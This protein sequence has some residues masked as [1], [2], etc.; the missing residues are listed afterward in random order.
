M[1]KRGNTYTMLATV[2]GYDLTQAEWVILTVKPINRPSIEF[3]KAH[4][5]LAY[6]DGKT[7]IAYKLT[8]E[9]S[10]SMDTTQMS[11][12]VNWMLNG[13]RG[14]TRIKTIPIDRTLLARVIGGFPDMTPAPEPE[15]QADE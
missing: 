15:E 2:A 11:I 12:D 10:V 6:G 9:Q 14:G 3:D 13:N 5:N 4:M 7:T 8:E 1:S